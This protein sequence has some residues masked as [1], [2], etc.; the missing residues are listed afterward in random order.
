MENKALKLALA[1]VAIRL[2]IAPFFMHTWD[3]TTIIVSSDQFLKGVSPYAYVLQQTESLYENT[4]L[5]L[6]YHGF[7][8]LPTVL[9]VFAPFYWI[10]LT[11]FGSAPLVGGHGDIYTGLRLVYPQ[12]YYGLLLIK[13]PVILADG[14]VIYLLYSRNAGAAKVYAFS[15]YII[16]VTSVWGNFDSLIGL[17]LLL[18]YIAFDRSK[19]LSGFFYGV[20]MMKLYTIVC[21][22]AFL[23]RLMK[24]PRE[25]LKFLAGAAVSQIPTFYYLICEPKTFLGAVVFQAVRPV[26]GVNLYYSMVAVRGLE[27]TLLLTKLVLLAFAAAIIVVS[28]YYAKRG[29]ELNEAITGLMLAYVVFAPVTNEQLLAAIVPIG[30]LSRNF[31]HKLTVFPLLYIAFNSTYHYFAIPIFFSNTVIREAWEGFNALWGLWVKDYQLQLR[32][33]FGLGLGFSS[34]WLLT[35]SLIP[36]RIAVKLQIPSLRRPGGA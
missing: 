3:V 19:V 13:L 35:S 1:A 16:V 32:Y 10:Y 17:F 11:L 24:Q 9:I 18:S 6:P 34:F 33:L 2:A 20:S 36:Q 27:E 23:S 12:L 21:M 14:A 15:P 29:V 25:L 8:Y 4:G 28:V 31:S 30:L 26:N 5:H 22:G 7:L